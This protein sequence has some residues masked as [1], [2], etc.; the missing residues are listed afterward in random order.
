[1][2]RCFGWSL[3]ATMLCPFADFINHNTNASTHYFV[4]LTHERS[5]NPP[6]TYIR[7]T[8]K[9]DLSLFESYGIT[10]PNENLSDRFFYIARNRI[11][12]LDKN[13]DFLS[14]EDAAFLNNKTYTDEDIKRIQYD[15]N[16]RIVRQDDRKQ[17]WD[18][19]WYDSSDGEDNDSD[20]SL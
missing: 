10:K 4:N 13:I 8:I 15:L 5:E 20:S 12:Y 2:T 1:M 14:K 18:F 7:K 11:K 19:F 9:T 17:I 16:E 6:D 3:P